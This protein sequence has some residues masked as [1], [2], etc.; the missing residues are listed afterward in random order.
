MIPGREQPLPEDFWAV[1][2][3]VTP[4]SVEAVE[5]EAQAASDSDEE[6]V[7]PDLDTSDASTQPEGPFTRDFIN[8]V[9]K[10]TGLGP[11]AEVWRV[12]N[13]HA[14]KYDKE[15]LETYKD[16]TDNLL[17]F[18][19]LFSAAV[20]AF[21]VLS[22][23]LLQADP[24]QA[25]LDALTT[26]SAQL[27]AQGAR[28]GAGVGPYQAGGHDFAPTSSVIFINGLW[29]TS[30]FLSLSTS[31]LAML[32]KQWMRVYST[33][34]PSTDRERANERQSRYDGLVGWQVAGIANSLPVLI[35]L[36]VALFLIGLTMYLS[37]L[38]SVLCDLMMVCVVLGGVGYLCLAASPLV[39]SHCP[40]KS[41]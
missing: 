33:G 8:D 21:I 32:V 41:P 26:I 34:L 20:T 27:S 30:L 12:Y 23:P 4:S 28:I 9:P 14:E 7:V 19:A 10:G 6:S 17:I 5:P 40:Y 18:A 35:H 39:W 22:L 1:V 31:V 3:E 25:T 15:M 37:N 24:S 11:E 13:T 29:I 16:G 2:A 36:A 38:S